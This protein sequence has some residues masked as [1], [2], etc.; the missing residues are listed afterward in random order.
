MFQKLNI[1]KRRASSDVRKHSSQYSNNHI[2]YEDS[3]YYPQKEQIDGTD[4]VS[5]RYSK[6]NIFTI[7][8][9]EEEQDLLETTT[10]ADVIRAIEMLNIDKV[11]TENPQGKSMLNLSHRRLGTDHL[12]RNH[13]LLL[14]NK[15]HSSSHTIHSPAQDISPIMMS[16]RKRI[17]SCV[18][19]NMYK[20][21]SIGK[22]SDADSL[23]K[24]ARSTPRFVHASQN[25]PMTSSKHRFSI[26]PAKLNK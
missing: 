12:Y 11:T 15:R 9:Y 16:K 17:Y 14:L 4:D 6:S 20:K 8:C 1:F 2:L 3:D 23:Q 22:L 18:A 7:P 25:S 5:C 10:M 21:N 26:R 24:S 19:E 13:N